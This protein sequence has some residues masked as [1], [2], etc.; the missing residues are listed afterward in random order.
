MSRNCVAAAIAVACLVS[1]EVEDA[2]AQE[3]PTPG[4]DVTAAEASV[5][6]P[7]VVNSPTQPISRPSERKP[8]AQGTS[9]AAEG[10]GQ[11]SKTTVSGGSTGTPAIA[12]GIFTL[13]QIDMIGGSTITNEAMWTFDKNSLDQA[14]NLLPGVSANNTG[15]SR[16]ER[17]IYVRGFDRFRVPLSIDGVRVYLP[18]DNRL[19]FARFLTPDL[20]EVQVAKG[21][22]SVLDGPGGIGGAI[23][24]VSRKPTKAVELEGRSEIDFSGTGTG[25]NGWNSYA[26]AGT[27][28]EKYYAQISGTFADQD[29]FN[30]SNDYQPTAIQSSGDR[31]H[32]S[33]QDWRLNVKAGY[34]PNASDEYSINY[35]KQVGQKEAPLHVD[36][37]VVQGPRYWNWPDWNLE[38]VSWLSKSQIGSAS[39][40][41]TNAYYN[42]F[43]NTLSSYDDATYT[44]QN[45]SSSFD[46]T[47]DDY[48]YGGSI[49]M[50]TN[51]IPMNTL[52]GAIIYR[53]DNH[54]E[55]NFNSPT[56]SKALLEP[57]QY[58]IENTWSFAVEN[59]FHATKRLD[60][61]AGI[62]YNLNEVVTAEDY[63]NGAVVD[64]AVKPTD[65]AF[66]YQGGLIYSLTDTGK[67]HAT[68]SSR[69]RFPTFFER[70]STRFGTAI[71]NPN[72]NPER[73]TNYELGWE[74]TLYGTTHLSSA[75]FY[76]DLQN[77]IQN[78]FV[79]S[80][81]SNAIQ[82]QNV[83]GQY[84]GW[85][86]SL[87]HDI[88]KTL[89]VGG[90]YTYLERDL[91]FTIPGAEAEGTPRH[92]GFIYLAW[93][94]NERLNI[95]P[96]AELASNRYS[97]I[98]GPD[99]TLLGPHPHPNYRD[100]GAYALANIDAEYKFGPNVTGSIGAKNL[101]DENYELVDGFPEAGRTLY[102][103]LRAKF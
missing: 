82:G 41:K 66:D 91:Y 24:L 23:N 76:S 27:R 33:F 72:L 42:T 6:P 99:S 14:V 10:A 15:G 103:K 1:F 83:D 95:T 9:A 52:K 40:V 37:Q 102:A 77:S 53:H 18:A 63:S 51:L 19:D 54:S 90:N 71:A 59:T 57:K 62:S 48:A 85:E 100:G 70:Y 88:T 80:K 5:L 50:G 36:G 94:V 13:G 43:Y 31:D 67:V 45:K 65:G 68:V 11:K 74:D 16:N 26:Y 39:Y 22:V 96:S 34:T 44:K 46:S 87:D 86:F 101:F 89:R 7:V 12:T 69:T 3:A 61:V 38:T 2:K 29:T 73:S 28:Q 64:N 30:L 79:S 49:E 78:V 21:Y 8:E 98:T 55:F 58:D 20:A 25:F 75:L 56:S 92:K 32:A 17:D 84:Y 47:Y 81:G 35:T 97:L 60:V 4:G 93:A